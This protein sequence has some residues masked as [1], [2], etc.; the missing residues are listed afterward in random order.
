MEY[1]KTGMHAKLKA[2]IVRRLSSRGIIPMGRF[3]ET[4]LTVIL[5]KCINLK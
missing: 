3:L 5:E 4:A 1:S 2:H